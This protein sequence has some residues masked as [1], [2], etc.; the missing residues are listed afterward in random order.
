MRLRKKLSFALIAC[1]LTSLISGCDNTS[2]QQTDNV[3]REHYPAQVALASMGETFQDSVTNLSVTQHVNR[4]E[5]P[6]KAQVTIEESGLLDDS[7]YAEKT[8]FTMSY[9]D[10]KWQIVS[11]VKTQQCRPERGHQDF[12]EKP[13]N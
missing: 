3:S 4:G 6:D 9:Q 5:S 13:C 12:S 1:S 2:T 8:V 10:D 11:Q 7:V